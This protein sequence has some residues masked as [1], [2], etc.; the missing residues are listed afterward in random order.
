MGYV[1]I[2]ECGDGSFYTGSTK[3]LKRRVWEHQN[4]LGANHTKKNQ[5]VKLL[6]FE[7]FDRID[8]AFY[9][10]KQL[11]GWSRK[12]KQALID[13]NYSELNKFSECQNETHCG[14]DS[15]QPPFGKSLG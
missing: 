1:Y 3:N 2:L 6:Y 11:Q 13:G 14:F 4:L 12:K 9:R 15:A 7:K 5:P 8:E 10:E